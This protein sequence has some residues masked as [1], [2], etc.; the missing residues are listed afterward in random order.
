M[1]TH[2]TYRRWL[3]PA[4]AL[5]LVAGCTV[6]RH[7]DSVPALPDPLHEHAR[8][9]PGTPPHLPDAAPPRSSRGNPPFYDVMGERY[10][11]L[12]ESR[13]YSEQGIASWYGREFHGRPT[14]SGEVYDMYAMT[15]AHKTLPLPTTARVTHLATGKS[16]VVRINDRGPFKKGRVIDL[17]YAAARELGILTAGTGQVEVQALEEFAGPPLRTAELARTMYLQIGA[18]GERRN[19]ENLEQALRARG[20][21]NVVVRRDNS[22]RSALHRVRIGPLTDAADF[23]RVARQIADLDLGVPQLVVESGQPAGGA[24]AAAGS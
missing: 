5:G 15:A 11:V 6:P 21:A 14:S 10:F 9:E 8:V 17:S 16:I 24:G 13:G 1:H 20:F 2:K 23:D 18:F 7:D 4:V 12:P 3:L 19:A 22:G